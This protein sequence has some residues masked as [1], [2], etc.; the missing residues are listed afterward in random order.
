MLQAQPLL[1]LPA[2]L[3]KHFG[4]FGTAQSHSNETTGPVSSVQGAHEG[5][6]ETIPC[7]EPD[8]LQRHLV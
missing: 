5:A 4:S 3:Q 7:V 1:L 8:E 2:V 6:L